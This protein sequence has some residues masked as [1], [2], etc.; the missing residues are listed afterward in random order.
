MT[1][2]IPSPF[3]GELFF[4]IK[5]PGGPSLKRRQPMWRPEQNTI[6]SMKLIVK[7]FTKPGEL[8]IYPC[9]GTFSTSHAFMLLAE[10]RC[11]VGGGDDSEPCI[12]A[13]PPVVLTFATQVLS[14]YSDVI[15]DEISVAAV[16]VYKKAMYKLNEKIRRKVEGPKGLFPVH[17]L[18]FIR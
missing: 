9:A 7:K 8:V 2:K 3:P 4:K 11:C 13:K 15:G 14:K 1:G 18:L 6:A 10:H 12:V 17:C 5:R 16:K